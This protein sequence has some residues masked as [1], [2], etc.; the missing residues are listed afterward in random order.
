MDV[1][2]QQERPNPL[3]VIDFENDRRFR[4]IVFSRG[5]EIPRWALLQI[6]SALPVD[7]RLFHADFDFTRSE[8]GL[9]VWSSEFDHIPLGNVVPSVIAWIDTEKL[10]AGLED[11]LR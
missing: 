3:Q 2:E 5:V 4:H 7:A 6:I 1:I 10:Q 9:G 11:E 8:Y